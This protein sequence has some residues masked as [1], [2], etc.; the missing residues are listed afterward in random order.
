MDL[1]I[2]QKEAKG[3]VAFQ[4]N[5]DNALLRDGT[6]DDITDAVNRC[7][8]RGGKIGHILNL[9]HGLYRDT[10]FENVR[11]LCERCE[12]GTELGSRNR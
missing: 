1:A 9:S 12:S 3:K 11:T 7:L 2:A 6:C 4:G 8:Q 5:V 10:P